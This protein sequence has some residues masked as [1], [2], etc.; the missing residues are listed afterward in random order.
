MKKVLLIVLFFSL[1]ILYAQKE[2][3]II[4]YKVYNVSKEKHKDA[5]VN[6]FLIKTNEDLA[7]LEF[8]LFFNAQESLFVVKEALEI[9]DNSYFRNMALAI[10]G[11]SNRIWYTDLNKLTMQYNFMN[12]LFLVEK[13]KDEIQWHLSKE[14]KKIGD[15]LCYKATC[16]L[17]N[18]GSKGLG[19]K[20][21]EVW[22]TKD[23]PIPLG[24]VG[25]IG[26]PGLI[27]EANFFK[28]SYVA[29]SIKIEKDEVVNIIK[30]NK[31]EK[32]TETDFLNLAVGKVKEYNEDIN[33]P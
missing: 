10:A 5:D 14:T 29:S 27:L 2:S 6:D 30:P 22:Y 33:N 13:A 24:P 23:I 20:K 11:A 16:T 8:E 9:D 19:E 15:Y 26:L 17:I 32:I 25:L 4:R 1:N 12:K 3:G 31:G 7:K 18:I 21:V 28:V